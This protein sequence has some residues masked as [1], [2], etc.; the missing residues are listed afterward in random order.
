MGRNGLLVAAVAAFLVA[1]CATPDSRST[2]DAAAASKDDKTYRTGSHLPAKEPVANTSDN[3]NA[4]TDMQT[5]RI[6]AGQG[7]VPSR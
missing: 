6:R 1:G 7:P 2:S 5:D 4:K 3:P